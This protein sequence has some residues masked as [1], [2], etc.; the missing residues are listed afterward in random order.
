MASASD[1]LKDEP[2]EDRGFHENKVATAR[3]YAQR[4]LVAAE[5]LRRKVE[6]G[7]ETVMALPVE[8]F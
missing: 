8:A 1:R 2:A 3:F 4:E 5:A 7:A 6:A